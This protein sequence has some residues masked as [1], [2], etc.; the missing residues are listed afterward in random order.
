MLDLAR[1]ERRHTLGSLL[2]PSGSAGAVLDGG[3]PDRAAGGGL[4]EKQWW[5][6]CLVGAVEAPFHCAARRHPLSCPCVF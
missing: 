3:S 4:M 2:A 1:S 6:L 5:C